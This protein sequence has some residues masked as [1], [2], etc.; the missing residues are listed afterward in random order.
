M[1]IR[2]DGRFIVPNGKRILRPGDHLLIIS[3][4]N[5]RK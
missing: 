3:E 4:E 1:M 5:Q 2:R